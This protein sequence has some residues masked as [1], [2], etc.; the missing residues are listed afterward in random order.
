MD[1]RNRTILRVAVIVSMF[2]FSGQAMAY[3]ISTDFVRS[4]LLDKSKGAPGVSKPPVANP[5]FSEKLSPEDAAGSIAHADA[6]RIAS[7]VIEPGDVRLRARDDDGKSVVQKRLANGKADEKIALE[8]S[9]YGLPVI[10]SSAG[11]LP[12]TIGQAGL[13]FNP[14]DPKELKDKIMSLVN[15]KKLYQDLQIKGLKRI[16]EFSYVRF[17]D[18]LLNIIDNK[19]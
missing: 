16:E 1:L 11:A 12:E 14:R 10:A 5:G 4:H 17:R 18:S 19:W 9:G 2:G 15:N 13:L 6:R 8:R 7:F 3:F